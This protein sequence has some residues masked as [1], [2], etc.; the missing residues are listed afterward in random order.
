VA[1]AAS[2][3]A[4]QVS[5]AVTTTVGLPEPASKCRASASWPSTPF[6][7]PWMASE[8]VMPEAS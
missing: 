1:A 5:S 7:S 3:T 4:G 6:D 8:N 2:A